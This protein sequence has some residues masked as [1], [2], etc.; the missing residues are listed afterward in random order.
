[1]HLLSQSIYPS[2]SYNIN[3]SVCNHFIIMNI[4]HFLTLCYLFFC[5]G[6]VFFVVL[7]IPMWTFSFVVAVLWKSC[8]L[9]SR[10]DFVCFSNIII[11]IKRCMFFNEC[12]NDELHHQTWSFSNQLNFARWRCWNIVIKSVR[13][14]I[15][16]A[17]ARGKECVWERERERER[18]KFYRRNFIKCSCV[19]G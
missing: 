8:I 2:Y 1:M 4:F 9:W 11:V 18:K 12:P 5:F 16:S 19:C 17:R 13:L 15:L 6:F 7:S 10:H 3:F 14:M